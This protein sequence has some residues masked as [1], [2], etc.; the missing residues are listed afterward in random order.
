MFAVVE[1]LAYQMYAARAYQMYVDSGV[2]HRG[3]CGSSGLGV[4]WAVAGSPAEGV[5]EEWAGFCHR[6]ALQSGG[7]FPPL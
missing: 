6:P 2:V 3:D 1:A 4:T 5:M 7:G